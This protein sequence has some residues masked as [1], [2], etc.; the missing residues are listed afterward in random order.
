MV[1]TIIKGTGNSR[2][3]KTIP[4]AAALYPDFDAFLAAMV[5]G[6]L[7]IDI[8]PLNPTGVQVRGTDLTKV[9]LL[10]DATAALY[11][12]PTTAIPDDIFATIP[13][14]ITAAKN[15][16]I[17]VESGSYEGISPYGGEKTLYSSFIW[18]IFYIYMVR[19]DNPSYMHHK[20]I[21]KPNGHG[22]QWDN[23]S[24]TSDTTAKSVGDNYITSM[25]NYSPIT[26]H[27]T[28][29]CLKEVQPWKR[30]TSPSSSL[31]F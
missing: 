25:D 8:G 29:F 7:P 11:G 28:F 15:A 12:K 17:L 16:G 21:F 22:L 19:K 26:Y 4:N 10:K 18:K 6:T 9:N 31:R 20:I 24:S 14:M 1:D 13:P 27:Y 2:T 3:L 5:A 23:G 30:P